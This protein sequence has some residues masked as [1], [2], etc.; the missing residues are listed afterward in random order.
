MLNYMV[1]LV[2][3]HSGTEQPTISLLMPFQS[4]KE[5]NIV[6]ARAPKDSAVKFAC[7]KIDIKPLDE[8]ESV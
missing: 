1:F 7:I 2:M 4:A 3:L 8:G 6:L 5:C